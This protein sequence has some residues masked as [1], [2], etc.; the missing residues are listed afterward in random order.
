LVAV[1]ERYEEEALRVRR[2]MRSVGP[3]P[4]LVYWVSSREAKTNPKTEKR[5]TRREWKRGALA[6]YEAKDK[7]RAAAN[8]RSVP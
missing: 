7:P 5:M 2:G 8:G 4:R 6:L 3:P 1:S